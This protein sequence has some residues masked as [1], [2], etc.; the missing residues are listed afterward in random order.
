[1]VFTGTYRLQTNDH[2]NEY[3]KA[4]SKLLVFDRLTFCLCMKNNEKV[5]QTFCPTNFYTKNMSR[6]SANFI[7]QKISLK[8]IGEQGG[9]LR[10]GYPL[11]KKKFMTPPLTLKMTPT[12]SE[13]AFDPLPGFSAF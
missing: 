7:K 5:R 3:L 12:P 9:W 4:L 8:I 11:L 13:M 2:Y 1:M 10:G 6:E